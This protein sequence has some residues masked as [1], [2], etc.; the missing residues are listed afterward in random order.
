LGAVKKAGSK[1]KYRV[2]YILRNV[3][4]LFSLQ[5]IFCIYKEFLQSLKGSLMTSQLYDQW[6]AV[7][8]NVNDMQKLAAVQR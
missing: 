2:D 8:E 6:I 1:L 4:N 7:P 5:N 3:H